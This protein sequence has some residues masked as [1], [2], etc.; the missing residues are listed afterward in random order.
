M[1][2]SKTVSCLALGTSPFREKTGRNRAEDSLNQLTAEI[3]EREEEI[4]SITPRFQVLCKLSF[5]L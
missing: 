4:A 1:S 2:I 5:V 3:N